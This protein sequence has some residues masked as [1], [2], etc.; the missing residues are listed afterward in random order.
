MAAKL[1]KRALAEFS[2]VVTEE[3]QPVKK[4]RLI[5]RSAAPVISLNLSSAS[6]AQEVLFLL[7]KLEENL[8]TEKD[9]AEHVYAELLEH[10][11]G[12]RSSIVRCK[13]VAIFAHLVLVT[14]FNTHLFAEDLLNRI[15]SENSHKVKTQIFTTL[16]D[17]SH[18]F[19]GSNAFVRRFMRAAFKHVSHRSHSVRS[20]CLQLIGCLGACEQQHQD[21]PASPDWP[22]SV[23]EV[24]TRY[25]SDSDPRV[26]CSA[27]E[28]MLTLHEGGKTLSFSAYSRACS[29]LMDDY[30][31]VRLAAMQQIWVLCH[32]YPENHVQVANSSEELRLVDD[33]FAKICNMV[34]DISVKVRVKAAQLLGSLQQVGPRFLEQTLDKK[35]MSMLRRKQSAHERAREQFSAGEWST[36]QKWADDAP[37]EDVNPDTVNLLS[38]G[39]CGAFVHGLEDEFLEVRNAT[40]DSL[41]ELA[42]NSPSFSDMCQDSII[43]MFNDEIESVRLNAINSLRKI[44]HNLQLREDQ[45]DIIVGVLKDFSDVSREAL[46]NMLG[47]VRL[48]TKAGLNSCVMALLDNLTRYPQDKMSV[49]RCA[50]KLGLGH[51]SHALAL[52]PDLLCLH[53]Y[54][55][56]PEADMDDPAYIT[57]LILVFNAAAL[58]PSMVPLFPE[59]TR[60][61]YQYLR[62]SLP[63]L[64]PSI[65]SL[66]T[67]GEA[68]VDKLITRQDLKTD[69]SRL[70]PESSAGRFLYDLTR[71]LSGLESLPLATN[72]SILKAVVRDLEQIKQ[73]DDKVSASADCMCV[74]LQSQLL[75]TKLLILVT[76]PSQCVADSESVVSSVDKILEL[77]T[78]LQTVFLGLSGSLLWSVRQLELKALTAQM[79]VA[80]G[81]GSLAEKVR[82]CETFRNA[83]ALLVRSLECEPGGS[84]G[85]SPDPCTRHLLT[86]VDRIDSS[87]LQG[88]HTVVQ[89]A[90]A[91]LRPGPG[92]ALSHLTGVRRVG[93]TL[94]QPVENLETPVKMAAGLTAAIRVVASVENLVDVCA[95]RIQVKY[96]DQQSQLMKPPPQA[97]TQLSTLN[98]QLDTEVVMSHALWSESCAVEVS[99][100]LEPRGQHLRPSAKKQDMVEITAPVKVLVSTKPHKL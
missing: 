57:V 84:G 69:R 40:L 43:D 22:V 90:L 17:V 30:E 50:Q 87:Q 36:G 48:E 26:R 59:H 8:P 55:D 44:S 79:V 47:L 9:C 39:A 33:G 81:R 18:V 19:T 98:H 4:L 52:T 94:I 14:G 76:N 86:N 28:A 51:P 73:L 12:E 71:R 91:L 1:K 15:E 75:M 77:T 95:L 21:T 29:A 80:L 10:L 25:I 96:P 45:V 23:P 83:L 67:I 65:P 54:L 63:D 49:W 37:K 62:S 13:I 38:I 53:P 72:V 61:H 5:Q 42:S 64:V 82:T 24:L 74:Y 70:G 16:K 92:S 31:G 11:N 3:P 34:T 46:R 66:A 7:L 6:S 93:A 68:D 2:H 35:L 41:C 27:F 89:G 97:W 100:V 32:I 58:S 20:A 60:R 56:T 85:L 99:L 78:R 88:T